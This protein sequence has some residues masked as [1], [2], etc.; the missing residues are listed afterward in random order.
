MVEVL[1]VKKPSSMNDDL[2]E[3]IISNRNQNLYVTIRGACYYKPTGPLCMQLL[4]LE[5]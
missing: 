1:N 2:F 3:K 5:G 4:I